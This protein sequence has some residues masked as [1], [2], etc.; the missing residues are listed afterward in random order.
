MEI[1]SQIEPVLI[2]PRQKPILMGILLVLATVLLYGPVRQH[3]F[4]AFLDD[5]FY[6]TKNIHVNTGLHFRNVVWA[7]S[8]FYEANWHPLTWL[9]HM[10]DCQLFGVVS[11]PQHIMNVL[12]HALNVLLLFALLRSAT[13]ALWR[14]LLVAALFAVHPLNVETVA[15]VAERKSLLC[16]FFSLVTIATYGRY[17]RRSSWRTYLVLVGAFSLALMSKP[18]AVSLPIPCC[19]SITGRCKGMKISLLGAGG[20]IW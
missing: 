10:A 9:S 20:L 8:S 4:L 19:Y 3:E 2:K 14:S 6:V 12:L 17:V 1:G 16:T 13:G 5:D 15:W 11:G 18:M 7:F